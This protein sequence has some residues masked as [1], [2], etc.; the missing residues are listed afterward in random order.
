[1]IGLKIVSGMRGEGGR[2][3]DTSVLKELQI[4]SKPTQPV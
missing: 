2:G 3:D 1:M 4:V